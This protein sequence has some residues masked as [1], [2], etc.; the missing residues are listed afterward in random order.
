MSGFTLIETLVGLAELFGEVGQT[1]HMVLE[2]QMVHVLGGKF[3]LGL[4]ALVGLLEPFGLLGMAEQ[5]GAFGLFNLPRLLLYF[6]LVG[7]VLCSGIVLDAFIEL[8]QAIVD[9]IDM[10]GA[11]SCFDRV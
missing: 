7:I 4:E 9:A 3:Q 11:K 10:V 8:F 2:V 1:Y 5:W 6:C